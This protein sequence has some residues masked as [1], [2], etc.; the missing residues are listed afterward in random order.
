MASGAASIFLVVGEAVGQFRVRALAVDGRREAEGRH[1]AS[2]KPF[3][4]RWLEVLER[5]LGSKPRA[6]LAVPRLPQVLRSVSRRPG[7]D[8]VVV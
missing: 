2:W 4:G 5:A 3:F 1:D 7:E 6:G 8:W